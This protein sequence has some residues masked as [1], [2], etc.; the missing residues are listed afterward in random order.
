MSVLLDSIT[1]C[2]S[3]NSMLTVVSILVYMAIYDVV[4]QSGLPRFQLYSAM[5]VSNLY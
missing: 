2:S 3:M 5:P 4:I 1:H